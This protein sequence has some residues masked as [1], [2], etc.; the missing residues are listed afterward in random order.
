M[1]WKK[2]KIKYILK[3]IK[4]NVWITCQTDTNTKKESKTFYNCHFKTSEVKK[5]FMLKVTFYYFN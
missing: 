2:Y 1:L 3:E 4:M 5:L